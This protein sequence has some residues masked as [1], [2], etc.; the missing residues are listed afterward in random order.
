[1]NNDQH[2][3][4]EG[5]HNHQAADGPP[6]TAIVELPGL[7][8]Q[9]MAYIEVD[10]LAIVEGDIVLGTVDEIEAT[11]GVVQLPGPSGDEPQSGVVVDGERFR[12][13]NGL[14]PYE[15]RAGFS[16]SDRQEILEA[17]AHWHAKTNLRFVPRTSQADYVFFRP[18]SGCS[19]FVGMRGGAQPITLAGGCSKGNVIHEIGHAVGL[20]HEHT[21]EDRD[22]YVTVHYGNIQPG[23]V[24][25]FQKRIS[26]GI[27]VGRY[28]YGSIMHYPRKAFSRN[29]QDTIVP[30]QAGVTI[31]QR[32]GLSGGDIATV[33][34]MY[35]NLE[36]SREWQGVQFRGSVP[37]NS[38][39]T[40]FTH[41]WPT[42]RYVHWS[43]MPTAP[44]NNGGRQLS[45]EVTVSRQDDRL[46]KYYLTVTNHSG[47][48]VS[49]DARYAVLGWSRAS[50]DEEQADGEGTDVLDGGA[51][52]LDAQ[53]QLEEP[54]DREA[55]TNGHHGAHGELVDAGGAARR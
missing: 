30:R 47:A 49:F 12:W 55:G 38:T 16:A 6:K 50:R 14:V 28:D 40:W 15:I 5:E 48:T 8:P 4:V 35:P 34:W 52:D 22:T 17:I 3:M 26:D 42:Y 33:R 11:D 53:G 7:P 10:G 32:T 21:R 13:T 46:A 54:E 24:G 23:A 20:W 18:G 2:D 29:G 31:G 39:R 19:S 1:M 41:S 36:P 9:P 51:A 27:D 44:N 43:L 25:N 45:L 37:A